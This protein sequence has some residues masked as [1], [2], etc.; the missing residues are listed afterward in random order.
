MAD[1]ITKYY[2][3]NSV[4]EEIHGW[5]DLTKRCLEPNAFNEPGFILPILNCVPA[6]SSQRFL[7]VWEPG[8]NGRLLGLCH[9]ET[10][11]PLLVGRMLRGCYHGYSELSL[12]ILDRT[13]AFDVLEI[14]LERLAHDYPSCRAIIFPLVPL[15]GPTYAVLSSLAQNIGHS[16]HVSTRYERAVL[17]RPDDSKSPVKIGSASRRSS[18]ARRYRSLE[19]YGQVAFT[20][21]EK[22]SSVA[23]AVEEFLK[24]EASGWKGRSG[25]ALVTASGP[26]AFV[27]EMT[28]QLAQ[29]GQCRIA[30]LAL[31]GQSVAS[32]I[33][34][35]SGGH[36]FWWKIAY[37]ETYARMSPGA[38]L[39]FDL[40]KAQIQRPEIVMTDSCAQPGNTL[41]EPLWPDRQ[42]IGNVMI[43]LSAANQR[44]FKRIVYLIKLR[45]RIGFALR[46]VLGFLRSTIF[47]R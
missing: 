46:S 11:S 3:K 16:L 4:V 23:E 25:D 1:L 18:L 34:I 19:K 24:L 27:R 6:A 42:P 28:A 13:M 45:R 39:A 30:R 15:S 8:E 10:I 17:R 44:G 21:A 33:L 36:S 40:S 5:T 26:A 29:S 2:D 35:E 20:M 37:D 22:P 41:I 7:S 43:A 38:L 32:G 9:F 47:R 31:N 12:P 14:M